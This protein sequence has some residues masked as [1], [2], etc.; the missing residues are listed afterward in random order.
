[1]A[2]CL[3][4]LIDAIFDAVNPD[5]CSVFLLDDSLQYMEEYRHTAYRDDR[6]IRCI[7]A[8]EGLGQKVSDPNARPNPALPALN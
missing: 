1:M 2:S 5:A 8:R 7:S 6:P 4:H 3:G